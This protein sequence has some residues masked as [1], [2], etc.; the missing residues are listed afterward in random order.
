MLVRATRIALTIARSAQP[1]DPRWDREKTAMLQLLRKG[2]AINPHYR[3]LT[4]IAA[5]AMAGWGD[6]K[7]A[8]WVWESVLASRPNVVG[9]LANVARGH[10]HAGD[11]AKASMYVERAKALQPS[12]PTVASLEVLLL[13]KTGRDSQAAARAQELL[14]SGVIDRDLVQLAYSLG[15]RLEKPALAILALERGINAT[16]SQATDGWLKLG[17]IYDS[18][19]MSDKNKALHAYRAALNT[20]PLSYRDA[21]LATIP[22]KY[23]A[24]L[25]QTTEPAVDQ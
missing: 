23:H 19:K 16:P 21:T 22:I 17:D 9:L 3:K 2:I 10:L 6:W 4:P 7:N 15:L 20:S 25:E 24:L 5:D 11:A 18:A 8:T 12:A 14:Q 1:G 13:S